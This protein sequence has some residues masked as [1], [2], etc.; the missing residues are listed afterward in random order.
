MEY[1][2]QPSFSDT[3]YPGK[4]RGTRRELLLQRVD[5]LVPCQSLDGRI[6]AHYPKAE[7]ERRPYPISLMLP[8]HCMQLFYNFCD[9]GMEYLLYEAESVRRFAGLKLSEALRDETSILNVRHLLGR[10]QLGWSLFEESTRTWITG[11]EVLERTTKYATIIEAPSY[12]KNLAGKRHP[13]MVRLGKGS[14]S[15]LG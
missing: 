8:V 12:T 11:T 6:R 5:G 9:L 15:I 10:H 2:G 4:K 13:E 7:I 14:S 1:D 3:E